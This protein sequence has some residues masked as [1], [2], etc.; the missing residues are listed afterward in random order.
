M[1]GNFPRYFN[2]LFLIQLIPSKKKI[3]TIDIQYRPGLNEK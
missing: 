2:L 1:I 3:Q